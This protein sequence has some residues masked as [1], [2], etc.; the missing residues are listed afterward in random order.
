MKP[1]I[2]FDIDRGIRGADSAEKTE[3]VDIH[4]NAQSH[5]EVKE[6]TI[7]YQMIPQVNGNPGWTLSGDLINPPKIP[8]F[9]I[10]FYVGEGVRIE[11]RD[12][13]ECL[14]ADRD[15]FPKNDMVSLRRGEK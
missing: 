4:V 14:V 7:L 13:A 3:K 5:V 12:G 11:I 10:K 9:P 6:D 15:G 2:S 1:M 8:S